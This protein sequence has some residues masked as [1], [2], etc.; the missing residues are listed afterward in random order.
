MALRAQ[1]KSSFVYK[2]R[3]TKTVKDRAN[4][5]GGG[6]DSPFKQGF[7]TYT[8][9]Q[10]DNAI[11][12]LPPTW[13]DS[14][15]YGYTVFMHFGIGPGFGSAYLCA[16]KMLNKKCPVCEAQKEAADAGEKD[17]AS[18]LRPSERVISW[19]LDRNGD[20]PEKP[21]LY[22]QSWTQDR[23]V[24]ALCVNDRTG[25]ILMIDHPDKGFDVIFKRKGTG[26][27]TDYYGWQIERSDSSIA[28][29]DKVQSAILDYVYENP[30]PTVLNFYEYD[31]LKGV[32]SGTVEAKDEALDDE[33][34]DVSPV[35]KGSTKPARNSKDEEDPPFDTKPD[36]G[37]RKAPRE[38]PEA[39]EEE[40]PPSRRSAAR[41]PEPEDD[42]EENEEEDSPPARKKQEAAPPPARCGRTVIEEVDEE[43]GEVTEGEEDPPPRRV[44]R[45]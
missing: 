13:D 3:D 10:G 17:E 7:D 38:E 45:R 14:D 25:E 6:F 18:A 15:H 28:D 4:R 5:T 23:D 22:N 26:L 24:T 9:S 2:P 11:R 42:P 30:I 35:R 21:V 20:D 37:S 29:S 12:Y 8:P 16:K 33:E 34:A 31:Y 41:K 32:L 39:E 36:R 27:K 40:A 44:G 43:T 19:V 1:K